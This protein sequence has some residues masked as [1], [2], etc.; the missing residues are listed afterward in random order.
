MA[1]ISSVLFSSAALKNDLT[2]GMRA[3]FPA[4]IKKHTKVNSS[5]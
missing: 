3:M 1:L 2:A 5:A 4:K